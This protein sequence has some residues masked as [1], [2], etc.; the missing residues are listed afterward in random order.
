MKEV[1]TG[2]KGEIGKVGGR[3][4]RLVPA[5]SHEHQWVGQNSFVWRCAGIVNGHP[6][7]AKAWRPEP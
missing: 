3:S 7:E 2:E 4:E 1:A 5:Q 6:C